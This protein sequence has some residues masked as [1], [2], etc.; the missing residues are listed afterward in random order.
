MLLGL[1]LLAKENSTAAMRLSRGEELKHTTV[2]SPFKTIHA[3]EK[4]Y[5]LL[6]EK[7]VWGRTVNNYGLIVLT[8]NS[9]FGNKLKAAILYDTIHVMYHSV[10]RQLRLH[11][12]GNNG[13][14]IFDDVSGYL[15]AAGNFNQS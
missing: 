12:K 8:E 13:I 15:A 1:L 4:W 5:L 6:Y 7:C 10:I 11:A 14:F 3:T 2:F 9:H